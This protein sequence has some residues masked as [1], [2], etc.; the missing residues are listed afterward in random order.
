M[1]DPGEQAHLNFTSDNEAPA[2]PKVLAAIS[3]ANEGFATAYA[4]DIWSKKLDA[5][6]SARF[7]I[8]CRVLPIA[9]GTAANCVGLGELSPSW[10]AILCH[11]SA[12][13]HNDECGAP[14]FYTGGA[15]LI[16]LPGQNGKLEARRVAEYL[17][18]AGAHGIHSTAPAVVAITQATECGTSYRP[19]E[20]RALADVA[21]ER[22]LALH[23]DGARLANAVAFLECSPAATTWKAGVDVLSFGATK[24]GAVTAEA[25]VLFGH[26][27][28]LEGMERR[29]KRGGHLLSKMR[30]VSAQLLAMLDQDLWLELSGHANRQAARLA[31]TIEAHPRLALEWPVEGNEVFLRAS[32]ALLAALRTQGFEFHIWPGTNDLARLVCSWATDDTAVEALSAA[33]DAC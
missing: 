17:D 33:L 11:E 4:E 19:E 28:R 6:F 9:T 16:P 29:R 22:G 1:S 14:E 10:G 32:P 27:E 21:H 30:Y 31:E 26:S 20:V 5:A 24:N 3:E 2:H 8:D 12:H 23:M 18:S 13:I 7:G 15:K 25:I